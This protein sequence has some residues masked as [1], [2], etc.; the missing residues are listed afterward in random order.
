MARA[1]REIEI[2]EFPEADRLE[3]FPHPRHAAQLFGHEDAQRM[4]MGAL[5]AGRLHHA[6]LVTGAQGIGKAT[7]AYRFAKYALSGAGDRRPDGGL[8]AVRE[9]A[10]G[11]RQVVSLSHPGLMVIRRP[12]DPKDKRF[13]ASITIDEVRRL[14]DFFAHTSGDGGWRVV[15]VDPVEDL[16]TNAANALL[17]SLEEPP[18]ACVF[19]LISSEPGRL[20][21]TIRSRCRVLQ[22]SPLTAAELDLAAR[23]A[24]GGDEADLPPEPELAMLAALSGGSVR[25]LLSL[26]GTDGGL[27]SQRVDGLLGRIGG[28]LDWPD[29][30]ALADELGPA[31]A[32]Q[33]FE[34][35][36]ELLLDR[37]AGAIRGL[38]TRDGSG[39]HVPGIA[40]EHLAAWAELWET[41]VR[42][43]AD[44]LALN[45]DRK[46]FVL[47]TVARLDAAARRT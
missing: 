4:L 39:G 2:E 11:A 35:F 20:L 6:W 40:P 27:L 30:H 43:K 47:E 26:A 31:V 5:A 23:Q 19:F 8:L 9:G 10:S 41:I 33:K 44:V 29:I 13:K 42:E 32:L 37:L 1:P 16:N 21:P 14:R 34:M 46:S 36:Y 15:I 3:G 28:R 7:L 17:K 12:Y 18:Q 25:R 45:L 24:F 22:L 38:A